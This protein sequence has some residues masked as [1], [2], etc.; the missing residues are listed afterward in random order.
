MKA[1]CSTLPAAIT[2]AR[3]D[4]ADHAWTAAKDGTT[5]RPPPK[6]NRKKSTSIRNPAKEV[7]KPAA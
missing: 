1:A 3:S 5:N 4:G 2:R 6:A 7:M